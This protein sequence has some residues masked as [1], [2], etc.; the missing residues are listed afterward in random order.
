MCPGRA[1]VTGFGRRSAGIGSTDIRS[2]QFS[3]S[4]LSTAKPMGE[5]SV[6]PYR[7]PAVQRTRSRSICMRLPLP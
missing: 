5:P 6:R 4:R 7:M 3:Q 1:R 2:V